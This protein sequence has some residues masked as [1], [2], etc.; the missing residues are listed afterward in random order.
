[1]IPAES[2]WGRYLGDK[3]EAGHTFYKH[4]NFYTIATVSRWLAGANMNIIECRSTLYQPPEH[5]AHKEE[6]HEVLDEKAGFVVIVARENH[7]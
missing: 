6:P 3:K 2:N 5:V 7:V 1:M 4:A